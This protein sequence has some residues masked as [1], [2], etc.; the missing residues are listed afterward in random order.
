MNLALNASQLRDPDMRR[1]SG[2][3]VAIVLA[4][5]GG[6][7][8][9][10]RP[11]TTS[12]TLSLEQQV[13]AAY[14]EFQ[15]ID[16]A[17]WNPPNPDHPLLAQ[18]ATGSELVRLRELLASDRSLGRIVRGQIDVS[19]RVVQLTDTRAVVDDCLLDH[20]GV[21]D[22]TSG[23]LLEPVDTERRRFTAVLIRESGRWKVSDLTEVP[24]GAGCSAS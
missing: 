23:S 8:R 12:T 24:G 13:L 17:V 5:C 15:N 19:P 10:T 9:A 22:T 7:G 6:S 20:T 3:I 21:Y 16:E 1:L 2:L 14:R 18:V 11:S 4:A